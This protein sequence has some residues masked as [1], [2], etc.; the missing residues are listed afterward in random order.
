MD[1]MPKIL[2]EEFPTSELQLDSLLKFDIRRQLLQLL[3]CIA[4]VDAFYVC[5]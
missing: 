4:D 1:I 2:Y 3:V 5:C